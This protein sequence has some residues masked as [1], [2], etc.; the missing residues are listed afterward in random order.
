VCAV[1]D[2][3]N[4]PQLEELQLRDQSTPAAAESLATI[5]VNEV[6]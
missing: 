6:E 3:S 2:P 5:A 4:V 1:F